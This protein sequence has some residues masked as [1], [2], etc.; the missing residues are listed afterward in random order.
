MTETTVASTL[1]D[2]GKAYR[3]DGKVALISGAAR[4]LGAEM[5]RALASAGARVMV[6]DVLE[7]AGRATAAEI[8][9]AGGKAE[10]MR[11]DTTQEAQWEAAVAATIASFGGLHI[12][13]NNAGIERL[14]FI[15]ETTVEEFRLVMDV[16]VTGVFLGC[17]HAVR[18]MRPGGPAGQGGSIINLSSVAGLA[19]VTGLGSY[20]ASKG[21]VR[22]LTKSVAVECGQLKLGIRCNSIHPGLVGTNMGR[23]L[24]QHF[25]DLQLVPDAAAATAAFEGAHPIGRMGSPDDIASAALYLASDAAKWV[26]GA[27]FV[28]DGGYTAI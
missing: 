28:I 22:L 20:C 4:G 16:N 15:T 19:G 25:V 3:V 17:K 23:D 21:A 27:E 10:F 26:T 5:A 11:L 18:A 6:T 2:Y 7:S 12:V 24:L 1:A 8:C 14:Q 9:A 13:I